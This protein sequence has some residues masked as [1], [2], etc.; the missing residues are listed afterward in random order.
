MRVPPTKFVAGRHREWVLILSGDRIASV[1]SHDGFLDA[2]RDEALGIPPQIKR[3][4][5]IYLISELDGTLRAACS[6]TLGFDPRGRIPPEFSL[7]LRELATRSGDGPDLGA[8]PTRLAHRTQC[9]IPWHAERLWGDN[10]E[11]RPL[12]DA[13]QQ[14]LCSRLRGR[15]KGLPE[16][17]D[18]SGRRITDDGTV[19]DLAARKAEKVFG[20]DNTLD[21]GQL[22]RGRQLIRKRTAT[23]EHATGG[24]RAWTREQVEALKARHRNEIA[25][26][27]QEIELLRRRLR[28]AETADR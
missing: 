3:V 6:F 4:H 22:A 18:E 11:L 24:Q 15:G 1:R 9:S 21:P 8:G 12:L 5:A 23:G 14:L 26:L 7:P 10:D 16:R 19:V 28:A 27:Q 2:I 13:A 17:R 25:M 20:P